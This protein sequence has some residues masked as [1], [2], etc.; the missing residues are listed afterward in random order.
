MTGNFQHPFQCVQFLDRRSAGRQD[1]LVASSGSKIYSYAAES[2]QR[3]AI[4]PQTV[5]GSQEPPEKKRRVSNAAEPTCEANKPAG[6]DPEKPPVSTAWSN[7]PLLIAS[8]SG[9][10]VV[11]LTAEDKCVRVFAVNEDG[12]LEQLN[13]RYENQY[14][15]EID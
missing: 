10:H 7:I 1:L 12:A 6:E 8:S 11:A 14:S 13:A 5:E 9:E 4:W 15:F 3:L 2:G